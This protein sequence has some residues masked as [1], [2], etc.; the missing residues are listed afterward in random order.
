M[1]TYRWKH[2]L[3]TEDGEDQG[4]QGIG[5]LISPQGIVGATKELI[6]DLGLDDKW[7]DPLFFH[8][9]SYYNK[10]ENSYS[11]IYLSDNNREYIEIRLVGE[12]NRSW[13]AK[14]E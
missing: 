12:G 3:I 2:V 11:Q 8:N 7:E 14:D 10:T 6:K 13:E 9:N 4:Q 5:M 1:K